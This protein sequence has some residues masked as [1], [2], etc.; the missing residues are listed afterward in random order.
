STSSTAPPTRL[1]R[2]SI[3]TAGRRP[4]LPASLSDPTGFAAS[5][6]EAGG[7]QSKNKPKPL[8]H[9]HLGSTSQP[10]P[11]QATRA[12]TAPMPRSHPAPE[13]DLND[14]ENLPSPF[15]KRTDR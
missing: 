13:Y 6:P 11:P 10:I 4:T 3:R 15:L 12:N 14:E 5:T 9:P 7:S 8:P 1:R 2:P